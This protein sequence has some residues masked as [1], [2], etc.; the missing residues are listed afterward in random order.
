VLRK[1][2]TEVLDD[3]RELAETPEL[4][5]KSAAHQ[6]RQQTGAVACS[7]APTVGRISAAMDAGA[8]RPPVMGVSESDVR[9]HVCARR[10]GPSSD[11]DRRLR[12]TGCASVEGHEVPEPR[13]RA[14]GGIP[15]PLSVARMSIPSATATPVN[16][17]MVAMAT[18]IGDHITEATP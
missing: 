3:F 12:V 11:L 8:N 14:A 18:R 13:P 7:A 1:R 2:A 9:R 10:R 6:G 17:N 4:G 16:Q 5:A 15:G